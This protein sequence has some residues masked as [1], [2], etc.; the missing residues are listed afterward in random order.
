MKVVIGQHYN[1]LSI[2]HAGDGVFQ[3]KVLEITEN[4]SYRIRVTAYTYEN[5]NGRK[6]NI[7][8]KTIPVSKKR[9]LSPVAQ[10]NKGFSSLLS[11]ED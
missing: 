11:K 1:I 2:N 10:T 3:G 9:I 4:G 7:I 8:G 6:S 5:T